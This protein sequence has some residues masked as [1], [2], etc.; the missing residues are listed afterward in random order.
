M[1]RALSLKGEFDPNANSQSPYFTSELITL[2]DAEIDKYYELEGDLTKYV[3]D[4]NSNE[5][6]SF[7]KIELPQGY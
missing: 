2:P 1:I 4:P 7:E 6:L 3:N 5:T